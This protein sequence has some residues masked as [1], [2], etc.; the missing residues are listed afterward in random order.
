MIVADLIAKAEETA[1]SPMAPHCVRLLTRTILWQRD[2]A[3]IRFACLPER[4][5]RSRAAP[6]A[7][8]G[9]SLSCKLFI[10]PFLRVGSLPRSITNIRPASFSWSGNAENSG[11]LP[12]PV[13]YLTNCRLTPACNF[14]LILSAVFCWKSRSFTFWFSTTTGEVLVVLQLVRQVPYATSTSSDSGSV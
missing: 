14:A 6:H 1:R 2:G 12:K 8:R 4:C 13:A 3:R 11:V 10:I 7:I 5:Q 9:H